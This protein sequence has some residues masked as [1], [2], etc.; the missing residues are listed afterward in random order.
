VV[1]T[2][3]KIAPGYGFFDLGNI[4]F[5]LLKA[6]WASDFTER[7][8]FNRIFPISLELKSHRSAKS[9][10]PHRLCKYPLKHASLERFSPV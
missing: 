7:F 2:L 1:F 9:P 10:T 8:E 5:C 6:M 3:A 4:V